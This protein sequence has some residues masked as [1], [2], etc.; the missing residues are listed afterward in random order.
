MLG[1]IKKNWKIVLIL[2]LFPII[3]IGILKLCIKYLPGEMIG[4]IDG[5]LGFLG[6]YFGVLGA[7]GAI[8]Y[9]K[10]LDLKNDIEKIELYSSYITQELFKILE[11]NSISLIDNFLNKFGS[12]D[13]TNKKNNHLKNKEIYKIKKD[14]E[15]INKDIVNSN[16]SIILSNK[17]FIFLL[18]LI[19]KL[20]D[21]QYYITLLEE[22]K[23]MNNIHKQ[24][25]DII[26]TKLYE[27]KEKYT[28]YIKLKEELWFIERLLFKLEINIFKKPLN[29]KNKD[30]LPKYKFLVNDIIRTFNKKNITNFDILKCYRG[31]LYELNNIIFN[32]L[33]NNFIQTDNCWYY[34][35]KVLNLINSILDIYLIIEKL[36]STK[37]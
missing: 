6:G 28:L 17:K 21:L 10:N 16:L 3:F 37:Q 33:D 32:M 34:Y 14:F 36:K 18:I 23:S 7:V 13:N 27:N 9:Q 5:W 25:I 19:N 26:D 29:L 4:S 31:C 22:N 30:I 35:Q 15:I 12:E 2:A 11:K 1:F 24:L 20:D 8:W